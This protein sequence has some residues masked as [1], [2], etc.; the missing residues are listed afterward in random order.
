[1]NKMTARFHRTLFASAA[2][3]ALILGGRLASH[4]DAQSLTYTSGQ[5]IS[6]AYEGWE[7]DANGAK[8]FVFGYMNKNWEEEPDVPIGA[9]NGFAPGAAD[10]GQPTH[11]LPRR[12]RFVFRVPV[13]QGFSDSD[14][15]TWTLTM[16]GKTQK[17]F[18]SL[19]PDYKIDDVV[20]ASETGA[21]GAGTSSPTVRANKP[22]IVKIEGTKTR[23]I[24]IGQPLTVVSAL[25]DDGIPKALS[26][27]EFTTR[28][29]A[30]IRAL[31]GGGA[32][33]AAAGAGAPAAGS[34]GAPAGGNPLGAALG[35]AA[36]ARFNPALLPPT[37]ITVG[38]NLGLH[39]SLFVYRG[40]G[41]VKI[42]P[43]PVKSWEDTRAGANSPWA[44]L[45]FAPPLPADGKVTSTVTFNTPGTYV[46]RAVADDGALTGYDDVTVTVTN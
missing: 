6:P 23:A 36:A 18:A 21:L 46:L 38:K 16:N 43:E 5:S 30:R 22:P 45:W 10:R 40:A 7:E 1:M 34:A 17:A 26:R 31:S 25:T 13:P 35:A 19:R 39:L 2:V 27:E 14:E 3:A 28:V 20:K 12:N 24:K 32:P 8:F 9:A 15:L 41:E 37:R 4:A 44:P 42:E 29:A 11:F 33:P